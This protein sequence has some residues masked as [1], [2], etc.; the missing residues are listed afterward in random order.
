MIVFKLLFALIGIKASHFLGNNPLSGLLIGLIVGHIVD[1]SAA[2]RLAQWQAKKIFAAQA[3]AVFENDFISSLFMIFGQIA[4]ASGPVSDK[5]IQTVK[6]IIK[7]MMKFDR[8]QSSLAFN[9]FI[10][11]AQ[12]PSTIQVSAVR[13]FEIYANHPEILESTIQ[14]FFAIACADAPL[15]SEEERLIHSAASVFG[16]DDSIYQSL[17][18]NYVGQSEVVQEIDHYYA[19][20]GCKKDDSENVIKS[21][22]RKLATKFH[23]DKIVSKELPEEF[24]EFA[25]QKFKDIQSAYELVKADKGFS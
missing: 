18:T 2:K 11:S 16:I 10:K 19:L 20:L 3:K 13:Y 23:P 25:N 12:T 22:Y 14:M 7:E 6:S 4:A 5:E 24:V 15:A 1:H 17:K 9:I 8:K 21:N